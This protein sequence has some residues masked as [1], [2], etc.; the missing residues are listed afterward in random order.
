[1]QGYTII[2][3]IYLIDHALTKYKYM[4]CRYSNNTLSAS[5]SSMGGENNYTVKSHL[6]SSD[7]HLF[8]QVLGRRGSTTD[9]Q[10]KPCESEVM[11]KGLQLIA[12]RDWLT[13]NDFRL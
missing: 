8:T 5:S 1:M 10:G 11:R 4:Y 12:A 9:M 2:D 3:T 6:A 7:Q 13:A